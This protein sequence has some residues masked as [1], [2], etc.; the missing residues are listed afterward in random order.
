MEKKIKKLKLS[1]VSKAD[2]EYKQMQQ[3]IG[4]LECCACACGGPSST[5]WNSSFNDAA[6][7]GGSGNGT[8]KCACCC[9]G[10][11]DV[12]AQWAGLNNWG[13]A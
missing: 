3:L 12:W 7:Y 2:L 1:Q 4:G 5:Y 10:P 9:D 13:I 11:G 6:N 8:E